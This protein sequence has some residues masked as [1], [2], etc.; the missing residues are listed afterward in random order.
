MALPAVLAALSPCLGVAYS[1]ALGVYTGYS[2]V[3]NAYELYQS[4]N[5]ATYQLKSLTAYRDN[6]NWLHEFTGVEWFKTKAQE[7][8]AAINIMQC[9]SENLGSGAHSSS[10]FAD[11]WP[12]HA[13]AVHNITV[14]GQ[15]C[16]L[17]T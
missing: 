15:M 10:D 8:D 16:D 13:Q 9:G 6:A 12:S 4:W 7:Y 1:A 17:L 14:N 11:L 3:T 5:D 2:V